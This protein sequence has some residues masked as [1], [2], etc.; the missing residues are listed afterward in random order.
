MGIRG[1]KVLIDKFAPSAIKMMKITT[2]NEGDES[3]MIAI[4]A[5][6]QL[7]RFLT[8]MIS[9]KSDGIKRN[10]GK[11][12]SHIYGIIKMTHAMLENKLVP[13]WVFDGN[14]P[15]IKQKTIDKRVKAKHD[16]SK[17]IPTAESAYERVSLMKQSVKISD[18]HIK[19]TKYLLE[20]LGIQYIQAI[21][22]ADT[23]LASLDKVGIT[24]GVITNDWD[25][26]AFGGSNMLKDFSMKQII[27][28]NRE[29]LLEK[30]QLTQ[31]QFI[32]LCNILG[33]DYCDGIPGFGPIEAYKSYVRFGYDVTKL[34]DTV[35]DDSF[36]KIKF[37]NDFNAAKHYY[38]SA[39]VINPK[40]L[41]L[42]WHEPNYDAISVYLKENSFSDDF[43]YNLNNSMKYLYKK[44]LIYSLTSSF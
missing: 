22:E 3:I 17:K 18:E 10:D 19:D 28:I 41:N 36:D 38:L 34:L 35:R 6:M 39:L 15:D 5:S 24:Q 21:G 44:Y 25:I 11:S 7:Y 42:T 12:I 43:I 9:E 2:Y 33:N 4:D 29:E 14:S 1:L 8:A 16:A 23:S 27:N 26:L 31:E 13:I 40:K 37:M 20:I 32:E 30:L